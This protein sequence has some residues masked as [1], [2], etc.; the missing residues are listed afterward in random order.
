M[1][2]EVLVYQNVF[3]F[4]ACKQGYI[5]FCMIFIKNSFDDDFYLFNIFSIVKT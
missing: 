4:E 1:C 3:L 5:L 2:L